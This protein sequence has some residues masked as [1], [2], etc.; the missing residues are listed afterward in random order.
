MD[1]IGQNRLQR[2]RQNR[3]QRQNRRQRR[4]VSPLAGKAARRL[5][6]GSA[7]RVASACR[8]KIGD[9]EGQS[10]VEA[11]F[12]LPVAFLVVLLLVQPGIV[13][14]D[15][16]VMEGAA[17]EGCRLLATTPEG[18]GGKS[19][20]QCEAYVRRRLGAVPQQEC[21]HVHDGGCTWNIELEGDEASRNVRV[22]IET[23]VKPLP[24][25]DAGGVLLGFANERGNIVVKVSETYRTQPEW[26]GN[27][28]TGNSPAAWVGAWLNG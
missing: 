1:A 25:F 18:E 26:V 6:A 23:E 20:A 21:F 27:V 5:R 14:Y 8:K 11:A 10:T 3:L 24:L 7:S 22:T 9:S 4:K 13:L 28:S 15:R 16:M 17:A 2:Q 19:A 12:M